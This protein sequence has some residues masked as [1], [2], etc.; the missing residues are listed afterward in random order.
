MTGA[1]PPARHRPRSRR[2]RIARAL[3]IGVLSLG[4]IYTWDGSRQPISGTGWELLL[5]QR[6]LGRPNSVTVLS[7]QA[8]FAQTW[9]A[10]RSTRPLPTVDFSRRVV[11]W[12]VDT[13]TLGCRSRIDGIRFDR[14]AR[15][16]T[17]L[18]GR[19]LVA[20][21]DEAAVPDAFLVAIDRDRLPPTPY[22][23]QLREVPLPDSPGAV[24]EVSGP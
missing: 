1:P 2:N 13:G 23:V 4:L 12:F 9:E 24:I 14:D 7:D 21:C 11:I 15:L 22:R 17:G 6:G 18:F 19:G 10:L 16:V 3:L 5:Q 20:F 8:S